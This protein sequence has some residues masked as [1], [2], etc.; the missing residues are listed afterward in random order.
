MSLKTQNPEAHWRKVADFVT[1]RCKET[2]DE[3]A[4]PYTP[5]GKFIYYGSKIKWNYHFLT[6]LGGVKSQW[7]RSDAWMH[8]NSLH[9]ADT[10]YATQDAGVVAFLGWLQEFG[11]SLESEAFYQEA[12]K[13]YEAYMKWL[14]NGEPYEKPLEP[15]YPEPKPKPRPAPEPEPDTP[16]LPRPA[17][18]WKGTLHTIGTVLLAAWFLVDW[19]VPIPGAIKAGIK[20]LIEALVNL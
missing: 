3:H 5:I 8:G 7:F 20:A 15:V 18:N 4:F 2:Y 13:E 9:R 1:K 17:P 16:Q 19:F 12:L 10:V 14:E 6:I 11:D